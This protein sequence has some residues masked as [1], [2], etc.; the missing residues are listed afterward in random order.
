M[1]QRI[2]SPLFFHPPSSHP[3][4]PKQLPSFP[5][6]LQKTLGLG[7]NPGEKK[8]QPLQAHVIAGSIL[9]DTPGTPSLLPWALPCPV[10]M[11]ATCC[12][13]EAVSIPVADCPINPSTLK[14][15]EEMEMTFLLHR[16]LVALKLNSLSNAVMQE[17]T[18]MDSTRD[19]IIKVCYYI[20]SNIS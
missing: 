19:N 10:S 11:V 7:R 5:L 20:N 12:R 9:G 14:R 2:S 1:H 16:G 4:M 8:C 15:E 13:A 18:F 6:S 17:G 3:C